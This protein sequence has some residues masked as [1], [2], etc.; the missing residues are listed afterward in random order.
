V[1]KLAFECKKI[2][3]ISISK[4][5]SRN[6]TAG[7]EWLSACI[8]Q[9]TNF[10]IRTPEATSLARAKSFKKENVNKFFD[11]LPKVLNKYTFLAAD[12]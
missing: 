2:H 9:N 4:V 11:L 6:K 7:F 12:I 10:D 5:W 8:N 1:T 3:N